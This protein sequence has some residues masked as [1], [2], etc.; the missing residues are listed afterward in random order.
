MKRLFAVLGIVSGIFSAACGS[1][2]PPAPRPSPGVSPAASPSTTAAPASCGN[3]SPV[4]HPQRLRLL[5]ACITFHGTV[6]ANLSE[7]DGDH[8]LWIAPDPGYER[9]LNAANVY[10]G[11]RAIVAEI[12]PA[13]TTEPADSAAAVRC[14]A[15]TLHPPAA[16]QRVQVI[17]PHVLD[18]VHG[19]QEVHPV[20]SIAAIG[21]SPPFGLRI[22]TPDPTDHLD[23]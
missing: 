15:S 16:G 9:Y 18:T 2:T 3:A 12:V 20:T 1:T 11:Q 8:H 13:C 10:H 19:W 17:G 21:G 23:D 6:L 5:D 22:P 14:P 4:Y 7:N